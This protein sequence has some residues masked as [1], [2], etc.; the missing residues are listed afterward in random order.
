MNT[1]HTTRSTTMS[2]QLTLWQCCHKEGLD[3]PEVSQATISRTHA[4]S[5]LDTESNLNNHTEYIKTMNN[6]DHMYSSEN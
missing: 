1:M 6:Y 4:T 3:S 5:L 2:K